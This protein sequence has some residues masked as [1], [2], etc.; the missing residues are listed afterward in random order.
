MGLSPGPGE[1]PTFG[2][3]PTRVLTSKDEDHK[4]QELEE[5]SQ[6]STSVA[7]PAE[8]LQF[9]GLLKI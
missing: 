4:Q 5:V 8:L 2:K 3:H 9:S 6:H 1:E 7:W